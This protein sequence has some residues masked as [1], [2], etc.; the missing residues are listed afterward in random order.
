[1]IRTKE[2]VNFLDVPLITNHNGEVIVKSSNTPTSLPQ[3]H[4]KL[5]PLSLQ[6]NADNWDLNGN[7]KKETQ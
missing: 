1:M 7:K 3:M 4:L 2:V 5:H 6:E